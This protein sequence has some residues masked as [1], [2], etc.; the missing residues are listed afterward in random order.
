MHSKWWHPSWRPERHKGSLKK[1]VLSEIVSYW[2][3]F[4]PLPASLSIF[5]FYSIVI[6]LKLVYFWGSV[7]KSFNPGED[8]SACIQLCEQ[9]WNTMGAEFENKI[10]FIVWL[11]TVLFPFL[12]DVKGCLSHYFILSG[13]N[14]SICEH[15][16]L[17]AMKVRKTSSPKNC[18][19]QYSKLVFGVPLVY[20]FI[21]VKRFICSGIQ[22]RT[23]SL[24]WWDY[25][26]ERIFC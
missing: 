18:F 15:F 24:P 19:S 25:L 17:I 9:H 14:L 11:G 20:F 21:V 26:L 6:A 1:Q 13:R 22:A 4:P 16:K 10:Y 23:D 12:W 5:H 7:R 2:S 8:A 3:E